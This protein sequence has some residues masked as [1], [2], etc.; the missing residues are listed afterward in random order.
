MVLW[1]RI[2]ALMETRIC[3]LNKQPGVRPLG[4]GCIVQHLIAKCAFKAGGANKKSVCGS[5]QLCTGLKAGIDGAIHAVLDK[6][7]KNKDMEF[8]E[9]EIDD[10]IWLKEVNKDEV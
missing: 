9:W 7:E 6:M 8:S 1:A 10:N 3:A 4:I 2:H 5:K